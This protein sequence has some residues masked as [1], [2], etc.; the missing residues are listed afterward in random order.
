M[1]KEIT[2]TFIHARTNTYVN[3]CVHVLAK[4]YRYEIHEEIIIKLLEIN[5]PMNT[6]TYTPI[7]HRTSVE[8]VRRQH[9][10]LPK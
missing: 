5:T 4:Q 10:H 9:V 2:N 6:H 8:N 7:T 3:K 1:G